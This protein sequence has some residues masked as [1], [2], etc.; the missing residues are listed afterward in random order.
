MVKVYFTPIKEGKITKDLRCR[1]GIISE[2]KISLDKVTN[3]PI[4]L[5]KLKGFDNWYSE[6]SLVRYS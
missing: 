2:I 1:Y 4:I 6:N 3:E 5:Y